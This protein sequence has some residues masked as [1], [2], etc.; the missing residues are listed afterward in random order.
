MSKINLISI[1]SCS[2]AAALLI[3]TIYLGLQCKIYLS[4]L[5]SIVKTSY[6]AAN[7]HEFQE[8]LLMVQFISFLSLEKL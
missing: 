2:L 4:Q 5:Q 3:L 7:G 6:S 1:R 8:Q